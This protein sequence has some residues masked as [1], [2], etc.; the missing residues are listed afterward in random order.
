[1][2]SM[3]LPQEPQAGE[4]ATNALKL[5]DGGS[6]LKLYPLGVKVVVLT[7]LVMFVVTL[8]A[9]VNP[10]LILL[11]PAGRAERVEEEPQ[12]SWT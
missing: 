12:V 10:R 11:K 8:H 2:P 7:P 1:M 9:A 3:T 6:K 4:A 5:Y